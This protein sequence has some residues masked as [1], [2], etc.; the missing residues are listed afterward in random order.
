MQISLRA[1]LAP[2]YTE[3]QKRLCKPVSNHQA[4]VSNFPEFPHTK[5]DTLPESEKVGF[6]SETASFVMTNA[7]RSC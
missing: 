1:D 7:V 2:G 6:F 5:A 4:N 3:D